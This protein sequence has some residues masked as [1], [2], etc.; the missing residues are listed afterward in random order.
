M[1]IKTDGLVIGNPG[2]GFYAFVV[3]DDKRVWYEEKGNVGE[4]VTNNIAEYTAV[5][6]AIEYVGRKL[7][8]DV[9][10]KSDSQ[11][12]INQINGSYKCKAGN[13]TPLLNTVNSLLRGIKHL[14]IKFEWIPRE[15][16]VEADD[17]C[18]EAYCIGFIQ[19]E[20]E[21]RANVMNPEEI[22]FESDGSFKVHNYKIDKE[23][24]ICGCNDFHY[25][26]QKLGIKCKHLILLEK[27]MNFLREIKN[28]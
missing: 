1:I 27:Y 22:S 8:G 3:Y 9:I 4:N 11:V 17:L 21:K 16:N 13:L 28:N 10:I 18:W 19:R 15:E 24:T 25:R 2:V 23:R 7:D 20:R 14:E 12:V 5:I 6:K 26:C